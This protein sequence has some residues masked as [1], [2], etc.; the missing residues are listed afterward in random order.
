MK[1][2][3]WI[4]SVQVVICLLSVPL[5]KCRSIRCEISADHGARADVFGK[6]NRSFFHRHDILRLTGLA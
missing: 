4:S 1:V 2:F 3:M 5:C 6:K